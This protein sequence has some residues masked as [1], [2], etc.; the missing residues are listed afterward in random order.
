MDRSTAAVIAISSLTF[1]VWL[2]ERQRVQRAKRRI[3]SLHCFRCGVDLSHAESLDL[4]V[5]GSPL[6]PTLAK[7]C[8]NCARKA[9]ARDAVI[10]F[11]LVASFVATVSL[12]W[13][14]A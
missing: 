2:I 5:A 3:S 6:V 8:L 1:V 4:R 14:V 12:I 9:K 10:W 13:L 7:F 11:L